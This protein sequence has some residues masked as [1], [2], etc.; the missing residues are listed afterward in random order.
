MMMERSLTLTKYNFSVNGT[1]FAQGYLL[2]DGHNR[3][4][5]LFRM[6]SVRLH[7]RLPVP[8]GTLVEA[9]MQD[10]GVRGK[11]LFQKGRFLLSLW[12]GEDDRPQTPH[13]SSSC[14]ASDSERC[15]LLAF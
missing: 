1:T 4:G 5:G 13:D 12:Q 15:G 10:E 7:K 2:E 6:G 8:E 3:G 9:Q 14:P 11:L